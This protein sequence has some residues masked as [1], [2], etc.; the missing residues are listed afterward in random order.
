MANRLKLPRNGTVGFTGWL[1]RF[2]PVYGGKFRCFGSMIGGLVFYHKGMP[3]IFFLPDQRY[4]EAS[5]LET[6]GRMR[7][8]PGNIRKPQ[9]NEGSFHS[10]RVKELCTSA[11]SAAIL[12]LLPQSYHPALARGARFAAS[13]G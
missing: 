12:P 13:P 8:I 6:V 1:D 4:V 7:T 3:R 5:D 9:R 10:K 11:V 2:E